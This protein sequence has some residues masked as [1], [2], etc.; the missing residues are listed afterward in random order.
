M[1]IGK[2]SAP[3]EK[4]GGGGREKGR[5]ERERGFAREEREKEEKKRKYITRGTFV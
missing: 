1:S 2:R 3:A 5:I 4:T